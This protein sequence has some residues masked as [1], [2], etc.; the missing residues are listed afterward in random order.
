[1]DELNNN[2]SG[3]PDN[4]KGIANTTIAVLIILALLISIIGTWAVLNSISTQKFT[5]SSSN[6][7]AIV[8]LNI[9]QPDVRTAT[10]R[11]TLELV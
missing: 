2:S 8:T 10:G 1:M 4:Q 6:N 3:L 9:K 11:I 5:Q 7:V